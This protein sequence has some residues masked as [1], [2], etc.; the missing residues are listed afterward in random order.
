VFL[1]FCF[2]WFFV[3]LIVVVIFV[4]LFVVLCCVVFFVAG[5]SRGAGWG[6]GREVGVRARFVVVGPRTRWE[7]V[8]CA[9]GGEV[10]KEERG[11]GAR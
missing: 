8:R 3:G 6:G 11:L 7:G 5:G 1:L 4:V 9:G 10:R 2:V